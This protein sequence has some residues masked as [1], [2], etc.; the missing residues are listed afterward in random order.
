MM[1][2]TFIMVKPDGVQRGLIGKVIERFENRGLKLVG[3]K[4]MKVSRSLA[5][6]HYEEHI[7]KPFYEPLLKY[8]TSGPILAMVWEGENAIAVCR[9]TMGKTNPQDAAPGTIRADFAMHISRNVVHGSDKPDSAKREIE[10]YFKPE[11]LIEYPKADEVW[12]YE[13]LMK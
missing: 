13:W 4:F 10:L 5:E 12:L 8:I 9:S 2:R 11:E 6:K 3:A 7:G 1:E